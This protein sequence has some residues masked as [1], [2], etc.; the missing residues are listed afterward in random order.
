[1]L[2]SAISATPGTLIVLTATR[3]YAASALSLIISIQI[4]TFHAL[5]AAFLSDNVSAALI[6][7]FASN[8]DLLNT[9]LT[10]WENASVL[11]AGTSQIHAP[12]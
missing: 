4:L 5:I 11:L 9:F 7:R 6:N 10:S 1:M 8:V 12:K 3:S 2:E